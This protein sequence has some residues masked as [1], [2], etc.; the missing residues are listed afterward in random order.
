MFYVLGLF[1]RSDFFVLFF[2]DWLGGTLDEAPS[3]ESVKNI[4]A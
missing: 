4:V 1:L 2:T 3:S